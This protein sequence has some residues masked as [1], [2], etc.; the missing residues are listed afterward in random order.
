MRRIL[1]LVVARL[2]GTAINQT[3][4]RTFLQRLGTLV[5][6]IVT[7][8]LFSVAARTNVI[9][10][11]EKLRAVIAGNVVARGDEGY[12]IWRQSM[13]WTALK[14]QRY[15]D[16]I[17]HP[18]S[19]GDVAAAVEVARANGLKVAVRSTG[20]S[21][22]HSGI[23]DGGMLI[24]LGLFREVS[25]NR[26]A[27]TAAIGPA[28]TG[29]E[30]Q[31]QLG[32]Q[33]LAFPV[34]HCGS[35]GMGGYLLGG[36][37]A[38]N[39]AAWGGCACFSIQAMDMVNAEGELIRVDDES[40]PE[41][42]WAARGIG[43]AFFGIVTRFHL[44]VYPLPKSITTSTYAWSLDRAVEA[45]TWM[46]KL[47]ETQPA[48][49]ESMAVLAA[50]PPEFAGQ[51]APHGRAIYIA[52]TAFVDTVEQAKAALQPFAEGELQK[53]CLF[54]D[55]FAATPFES[56]F[57]RLD[58]SFPRERCVADTYWSDEPLPVV[59]EELVDHFATAPSP[60]SMVLCGSRPQSYDYPDAAYSMDGNSFLAPYAMWS[61]PEED[62]THIA[63]LRKAMALLEPYKKGHFISEAD[64]AAE[65]SRA[66]QSFAKTNWQRIQALREK[67]D[68]GGLF[69]S[70]IGS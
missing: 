19:D 54:K 48:Y 60:L 46:A 6:S 58:M 43:P 32:G 35:V 22:C 5:A 27:Q 29:R 68:P 23:R 50:A 56:L 42:M 33:G 31:Q 13:V 34:P 28:I 14:P 38:W 63:W 40:H 20:H 11:A 41:I 4:R 2:T 36:G 15:P 66:E 7:L 3:S 51:T 55:E 26:D 62:A 49:V 69:Y 25:I 17:V 61:K 59:V 18:G 65:P 12:E 57:G 45:S 24:D 8:P 70:Y 39:G 37:Q 10:N 9:A 44:K 1:S 30:L 21:W 64:I 67:Y 53:A 52:V 16:L 47:A